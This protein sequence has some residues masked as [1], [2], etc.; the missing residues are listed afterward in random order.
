MIMTDLLRSLD[1][2]LDDTDITCTARHCHLIL[3][4]F[5]LSRDHDTHCVHY[6]ALIFLMPISDPV[7]LSH[8]YLALALINKINQVRVTGGE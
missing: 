2:I 7:T 3:S 6:L 8:T 5:T 4:L 1:Y